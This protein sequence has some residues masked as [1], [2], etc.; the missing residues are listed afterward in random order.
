[1]TKPIS[2]DYNQNLI[3]KIKTSK[4]NLNLLN[5]K[6]R[7]IREY[8][9]NHGTSLYQTKIHPYSPVKEEK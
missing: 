8:P 3:S 9:I 5:H 6:I 4:P 7:L 2:T 1:V